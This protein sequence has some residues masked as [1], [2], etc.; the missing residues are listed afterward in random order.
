VA[1]ALLELLEDSTE[2]FHVRSGAL[3]GLRGVSGRDKRLTD[4]L[5]NIVRATSEEPLLRGGAAALL[6][7]RATD[8]PEARRAL[9]AF[10][11]DA[12][13]GVGLRGA[14]VA[15]RWIGAHDPSAITA[16]IKLTR[17]QDL[18]VRSY[19]VEGC[20]RLWRESQMVIPTLF[21]FLDDERLKRDVLSGLLEILADGGLPEVEQAIGPIDSEEPAAPS[22]QG[23]SQ[24]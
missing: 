20:F 18:F 9:I 12:R 6:A 21:N 13:A 16:L 19:A 1:S 3:S 24:G 8:E 17:A 23:R 22:S 7:R 11:G 2:D 5:L 10:A 4:A 14:A 15:L